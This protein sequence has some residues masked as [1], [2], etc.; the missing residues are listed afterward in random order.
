MIP[1]QCKEYVRIG[2]SSTLQ[3]PVAVPIEKESK[4]KKK[5]TVV[6]RNGRLS[7]A[8]AKRVSPKKERTFEKG[9]YKREKGSLQW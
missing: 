8:Y 3:S 1:K 9:R 7:S 4:K 6:T 5:G 2:I